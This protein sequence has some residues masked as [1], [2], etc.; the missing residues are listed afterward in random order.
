MGYAGGAVAASAVA[1]AIKANGGIVKLEPK[2]F[3]A[4][5]GKANKPAVVMSNKSFWGG[6]H[7]YIMNY[8]GLFMYTQS[9]EPL[10]LPSDIELILAK[11]IMIPG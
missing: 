6:K 8:K 7:K 4:L 3:V 10:M 1:N 9:P 11:S 5:A 2:D